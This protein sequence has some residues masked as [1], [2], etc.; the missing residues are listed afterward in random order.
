[1]YPLTEEE[2]RPPHPCTRRPHL[3]KSMCHQPWTVCL[4]HLKKTKTKIPHVINKL[5]GMDLNNKSITPRHSYSLEKLRSHARV[6]NVEFN[7]GLSR[8]LTQDKSLKEKMNLLI[9]VNSKS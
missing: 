3:F 8:T 7:L 1:M 9:L 4:S 5:H 2:R 6:Y